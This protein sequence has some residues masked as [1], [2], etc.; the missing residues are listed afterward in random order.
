MIEMARSKLSLRR[1]CELLGIARSG[2]YY[3]PVEV[4]EEDLAIMRRLDELYME[5]PA[6]GARKLRQ[7]LRREGRPAGRER[8]QRLRN[9][10]GL[11]T[12]G[13]RPRLSV[14]APGVQRFPY[15][16]KELAID[17][18]DQVWCTDITYVPMARG[19]FYLAA[20]MDWYSRRVLGWKVSNTLEVGFCLEALE[21]AI[22]VA[23]RAPEILNTDQG[24]Q[25]TCAAWVDRVQSL[26]IRVSQDGK[27][28]W[29]DNVFIER[30]WRSVKHE[31][32]YPRCYAS[33]PELVAGLTRWFGRYNG[34][35]PHM[36]LGGLTPEEV[37]SGR[38]KEWGE[39]A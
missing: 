38:R 32:V 26:G 5:D 4:C 27:G 39:A 34:W 35:R 37:Y 33:G 6:L 36:A 13:P 17:H 30:L 8:I 3:T 24:C 29:T 18:P 12:I 16:L 21:D 11:A 31:D 25:F 14:P 1:Q 15:L 22:G 19:F 20:I 9:K 2:L 7:V 23:G 10:M 28:R